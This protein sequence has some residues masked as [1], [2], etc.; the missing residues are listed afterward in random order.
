[1][2]YGR[3]AFGMGPRRRGSKTWY[4]REVRKRVHLP[5]STG[6]GKSSYSGEHI[7]G[8][9]LR[10]QSIEQS[11]D[12]QLAGVMVL[13]FIPFVILFLLSTAVGVFIFIIF[14]VVVLGAQKSAPLFAGVK[15][16]TG[17]LGEVDSPFRCDACDK[18]ALYDWKL[19]ET[20][21][22]WTCSKCKA[23]TVWSIPYYA[24]QKCPNC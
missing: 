6:S 24:N 14:I 9:T 3:P 5:R 19:E 21:L 13:G 7:P 11:I 20:S 12:G 18:L 2:P 8:L 15:T 17:R 22:L 23:Q 16:V 10:I 1:M 4:A